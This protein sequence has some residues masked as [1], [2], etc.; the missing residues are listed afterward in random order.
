MHVLQDDLS[1]FQRFSV[2]GKILETLVWMESVLKQK[3]SGFVLCS[4]KSE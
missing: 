2:G 1:I 4:L 3:L